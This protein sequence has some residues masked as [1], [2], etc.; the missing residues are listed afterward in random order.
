MEPLSPEL[1][2]GSLELMVLSVLADGAKY[3]Y[4]IQQQL[5]TTSRDMVAVQAG[6]LYPV[7]HRLE[8]DK[9]IRAKWDES[10]GRPR[11]WYELT[12]AGRKRLVQR[13]QTWEAYVE[14]VRR[15]I[16]PGLETAP[17]PA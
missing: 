7:L 14:C 13:T 9:A 17:H 16:Q 15:V 6:T 10:T 5:R 2:R 11:K 3:G 8:R 1:L 12:A 4:L